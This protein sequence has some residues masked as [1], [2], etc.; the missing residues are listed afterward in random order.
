MQARLLGCS[1][2]LPIYP[3]GEL[4]QVWLGS[5]GG[6]HCQADHTKVE[7]KSLANNPILPLYYVLAWVLLITCV[8]GIRMDINL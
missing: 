2:S 5:R 4:G 8:F 6:E 1:S 7:G 3:V